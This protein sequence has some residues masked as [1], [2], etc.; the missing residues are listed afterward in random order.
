MTFDTPSKYDGAWVCLPNPGVEFEKPVC[1]VDFSSLYPTLGISYNVG[2]ETI[3]SRR[4]ILENNL[5]E[6]FDYETIN[7][8]A[9]DD[10]KKVDIRNLSDS[11]VGS[12]YV[13]FLK[14]KHVKSVY[15]EVWEDILE[16]R[17]KFKR[18]IGTF[19]EPGDN[20]RV[21]EMSD[22]FKIS[23]NSVYGVLTHMGQWRISAAITSRGR[24]NTRNVARDIEETHDSVT[25]YGDSVMPYTPITY[26]DENDRLFTSTI[27]TIAAKEDYSPYRV[28]KSHDGDD[29]D[30][31]RSRNKE[32]HIPEKPIYVLS[33]GGW[34]RVKRIVRHETR[35]KIYRVVTHTGIV[36]V[37]EDHSLLDRAGEMIAP[38][39]C[40]IG[41]TRLWHTDEKLVGNGDDNYVTE[42]L[43]YLFGMFIGDGSCGTYHTKSGT[44]YT[45]VINNLDRSLLEKCVDILKTVCD[46]NSVVLNTRKSSGVY[47]LVPVG[48]AYGTIR[49]LVES[50]RSEC[51][52]GS[53]KIVP[54]NILNSDNGDV[55]RSFNEGLFDS[56]RCRKTGCRRR[57]D[58]KNQVTAASYVLLFNLL[59]F[60][61]S[62]TDKPN[63]YRVSTGKQRRKDPLTVKKLRVLHESYDGYVYDME[64]EDG[65]FNAGIGKI[66]L[67]NTDSVMFHLNLTTDQ[68][69]RSYDSGELLSRGWLTGEQRID[70]CDGDDYKR[71]CLIAAA[72]S[73]RITEEMNGRHLS[74]RTKNAIYFP[75]SQLDHE[76]VMLPF[77]I[78][79]QKHYFAKI[80]DTADEPYILRGLEC[81]K[82]TKLQATDDV[83]NTMFADLLQQNPCTWN[84]YRLASEIVSRLIS[85]SVNLTKIASRKRIAVT[86]T[87]KKVDAGANLCRRMKERGELVDT[88]GLDKISVHVIKVEN[89]GDGKRVKYESLAYMSKRQRDELPL[90]LDAKAIARQILGETVKIMSV[91]HPR[92][93]CSYFA[94]L[95]QLKVDSLARREEFSAFVT[96][97]E[98][99]KQNVLHATRRSKPRLLNET[100]F[101]YFSPVQREDERLCENGKRKSTEDAITTAAKKLKRSA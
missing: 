7:I 35:K 68:L 11:E 76:K 57:I 42:P 40:S 8:Y 43:A 82:R 98:A 77:V 38:A 41:T 48:N 13:C 5:R 89:G 29:D 83:E 54:T 39:E 20:K 1:C 87:T 79:A 31:S 99:M 53:S 44:K 72:V 69:C 95:L 80:M 3:L 61:T 15:C 16:N 18:Q 71:G 21:R 10:H 59:G 26:K 2:P 45:W 37:T 101:N 70:D 92:S 100:I 22:T 24:Q 33:K 50:F 19:A 78:F 66:V 14:S 96:P 63:I 28:F 85:G 4:T 6:G 34:S 47:K 36:D 65:S 64:T 73:T 60:T 51:Y 27:E 52:L 62:V 58:T 25:V 32:Q 55:M 56:D 81:R 49:D 97:A 90:G 94:D 23:A 12:N 93:T 86:A 74:D 46:I 91:I 67:K 9:R 17:L 84:T 30:G 88:G 75:P